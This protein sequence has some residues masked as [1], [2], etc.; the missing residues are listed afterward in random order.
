MVFLVVLVGYG[1]Q[2]EVVATRA[3]VGARRG[4]PEVGGWR[5][6]RHGDRG[7]KEASSFRFGFSDGRWK[8]GWLGRYLGDP[9]SIEKMVGRRCWKTCRVT[10]AG[11][12]GFFSFFATKQPDRAR[13]H[14]RSIG[15]MSSS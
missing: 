11:F 4:G 14:A 9:I 15:R 12:D 7:G 13:Q 5:L 3:P 2:S 10:F 6:A 8:L 1:R